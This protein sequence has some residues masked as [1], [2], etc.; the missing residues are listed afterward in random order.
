MCINIHVH[1]HTYMGVP[2]G[3][4]GKESACQCGRHKRH[5]FDSRVGKI[6]WRRAWKSTPVFVPGEFYG[7]RSL[8]GYSPLGHKEL[9]M[10]ETTEHGHENTYIYIHT[11]MYILLDIYLY[12]NY[13][14]I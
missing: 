4:S 3:A 9:D 7:E 2:D 10:T 13:P 12:I 14:F 6:S 11:Y 1:T 5:G 8:V